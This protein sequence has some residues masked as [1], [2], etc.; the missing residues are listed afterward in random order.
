MC[1]Q[2]T[3]D[4]NYLYTQMYTE[5]RR[6]RDYETT[7]ATW[8]ATLLLALLGG[9]IAAQ[10]NRC[11]PGL[12]ENLLKQCCIKA[13]LTLAVV[14]IGAG[15]LHALHYTNIRYNTLRHECN[16]YFKDPQ[17]L[18]RIGTTLRTEHKGWTPLYT[19]VLIVITLI[20]AILFVIWA[21]PCASASGIVPASLWIGMA[22]WIWFS[23]LDRASV[24]GRTRTADEREP[25]TRFK[26]IRRDFCR[27]ITDL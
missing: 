4:A 9:L 22:V 12:A 20:G 25:E 3:P 21:G 15:L 13:F 8:W 10:G 1:N 6:Y 5:M 16:I 26:Q 18:K 14:S 7:V 24:P 27:C 11:P 19:I 17:E 2:D 23:R